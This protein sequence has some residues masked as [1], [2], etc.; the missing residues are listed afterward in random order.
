MTNLEQIYALAQQILTLA[1]APQSPPPPPASPPA[2]PPPPP[3]PAPPGR[4]VN[5]TTGVNLQGAVINMRSGDT[6]V[7]A[8]GTYVVPEV[9]W[10]PDGL[11]NITFRGATGNRDDVILT[12]GQG[13]GG[14]PTYAIWMQNVTGA[15]LQDFTCRG[16]TQHTLI[17]NPGCQS[18]ILRNLHLVDAAQQLVKVNPVNDA[19]GKAIDGCNNGLMEDCLLEYSTTAPNFYTNGIDVHHGANWIIRRNIFKNIRNTSQLAGHAILMWNGSKATLVEGN[20]FINNARDIALGLEANNTSPPDHSGG[21][22][23]NN[24]IWRAPG[25][26]GDLGI[27]VLNCPTAKVLNNTVML[28]GNYPNAIE[29]R[30]A[31]SNGS[32]AQNNLTDG[33]ITPRDGAQPTLTGNVTNAK[34]QWFVNAAGGDLHLVTGAPVPAGVGAQ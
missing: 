27:G 25:L 8:K 1:S 28:N 30:F 32:L 14:G 7:M 34:V 3:A 22:V 15:V 29:V 2:P 18:P 13:M 6:I 12:N 33:A 11:S 20:T 23:R 17:F 9:L 5:V 26:G 24:F 10:V 19:A 31:L 21:I 4:V 16:F